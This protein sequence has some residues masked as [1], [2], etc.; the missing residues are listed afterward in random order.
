MSPPFAK[1]C[2][3]ANQMALVSASQLPAKSCRQTYN[4]ETFETRKTDWALAFS[5]LHPDVAL[6]YNPLNADRKGPR[7]SQ[8]N[9][10]AT[11]KHILYSAVVV[12]V[13]GGN[14]VEAQA[15]LFTWFQAGVS[16]LRQILMKVGNGRP[17]PEPTHP[18]LGW[19]VIGGD[20]QFYVAFGDG[21]KEGDPVIILGPIQSMHCYMLTYFGTFK[22]L[23]LL[24]R[25]KD[26]AREVCWP[27]Y[28]ER[29]IEPLKLVKDRPRT[30]EE[31]AAEAGDRGRGRCSITY[32]DSGAVPG[33]HSGIQCDHDITAF[34]ACIRHGERVA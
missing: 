9:N 17:D 15:Q 31:A 33:G 26:W 18:L 29:V 8:M 4:R 21:N 2:T 19:T 32:L 24:E 13:P 25:V 10:D 28:R 11:S 22:L 20:W 12:K 5:P 23:Q 16:C 3:L 27:W 7:L 14:I 6:Q 30:A 1:L 34:L